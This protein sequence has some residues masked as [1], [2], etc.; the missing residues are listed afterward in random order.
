MRKKGGRRTP[1]KP[2]QAKASRGKL[3]RAKASQKATKASK[4]QAEASKSKPKQAKASKSNKSQQKPA[5]ASK[6]KKAKAS[7]KQAKAGK[8]KQK[9]AKGT[10][11]LTVTEVF[12]H[13]AVVSSRHELELACTSAGFVW[14]LSGIFYGRV[15]HREASSQSF[16][17]SL[18]DP[19]PF[20]EHSTV[21]F[22]P[23]SLPAPQPYSGPQVVTRCLA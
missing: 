3:K 12:C 6:S 20:A 9:Q 11:F 23:W 4:R 18:C 2:K 19:Q 21:G 13:V 7:T 16:A 17:M 8:H 14:F 5:K 1:S 15:D 22:S 10:H